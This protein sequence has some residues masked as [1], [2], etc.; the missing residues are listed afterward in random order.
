M[1]S[2]QERTIRQNSV[3]IIINIVWS[4]SVQRLFGPVATATERRSP[5]FHHQGNDSEGTKH[6]KME[7]Q[8]DNE[9]EHEQRV[10]VVMG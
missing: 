8:S 2:V 4:I 3:E 5:N 7:Q 6:E 1:F 9:H 10:E